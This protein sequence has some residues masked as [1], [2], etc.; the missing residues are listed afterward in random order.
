MGDPTSPQVRAAEELELV[1]TPSD[2]D[3]FEDIP[4]DSPPSPAVQISSSPEKKPTESPT[5]LSPA[6]EVSPAA[7]R[8]GSS[9]SRVKAAAAM[10]EASSSNGPSPSKVTPSKKPSS[11]VS[12]SASFRSIPASASGSIKPTP[13]R[14][15]PLERTPS[16]EPPRSPSP[17]PLKGAA[18]RQGLEESLLSP[19]IDSTPIAG[20]IDRFSD[21]P[22]T[23]GTPGPSDRTPRSASGSRVPSPLPPPP[24][25]LAPELPE[26]VVT[27]PSQPTSVK[28]SYF[29]SFG[30]ATPST[31]LSAE[32]TSVSQPP[33]RSAS[34]NSQQ[35]GWR[36]AVGNLFAA[37][38]ATASSV[39]F[40]S[41]STA[42]AT[43][44]SSHLA[45][46]SA[47]ARL[48]SPSRTPST[49]FLLHRIGDEA[50]S[51]DRR[52]SREMGGGDRL[53]A[54]FERVRGEMESAAR[55]MRRERQ[56]KAVAEPGDNE[57][58]SGVEGAIDWPFWGSVVQDYEEVARTRPKELS[59]AIQQGIP[60]VIR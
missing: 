21:V 12:S 41:S 47:P 30:F 5:K 52:I 43:G 24:A 36:S 23:V 57:E 8:K 42:P 50:A 55:D 33:Q 31:S 35:G 46:P 27:P 40:A 7:A 59:R 4:T 19:G 29:S 25:D 58:Q 22:L 13:V 3:V 16:R 51:R 6:N 20:R 39:D 17:S 2:T 28:T 45:A 1:G 15:P 60:A 18:I 38:S 37:R 10:F 44:G 32:P 54:G 53:R 11:A 34:S 48:P 9:P 49:S 26:P 56:G 14:S